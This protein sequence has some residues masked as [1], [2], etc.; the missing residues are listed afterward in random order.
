MN[1]N[2]VAFCHHQMMMAFSGGSKLRALNLNRRLN[3]STK[4]AYEQ[5]LQGKLEVQR[6]NSGSD[7]S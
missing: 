2:P 1:P 4:E 3:M 5:Q 7:K 6:L